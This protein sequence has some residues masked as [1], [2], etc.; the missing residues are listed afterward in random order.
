MNQQQKIQK[1]SRFTE[2]DFKLQNLAEKLNAK[3]TKD[4]PGYPKVLRTFEERR[5]DWMDN[6]ISKAIIIQPTFENDGVN[7]TI[8]NLINIAWF[9]DAKSILRPKW[10]KYL[11]EKKEFEIISQ[12]IDILIKQ[13][14]EN[15]VN[16][17]MENLK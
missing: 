3:L 16:I 7:S 13:S 6:G 12:N 5:I 2:I 1:M 8:W 14:E 17:K 9:D 11:I 10:K 15:L 4:R